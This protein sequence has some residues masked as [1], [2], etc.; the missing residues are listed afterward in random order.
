[1]NVTGEAVY[2]NGVL[3]PDQPLPLN[4][5]QRVRISVQPLPDDPGAMRREL[6]RRLA[7]R[8]QQLLSLVGDVALSP[9][10]QLLKRELAQGHELLG[11]SAG[12]EGF[13]SP[14]VLVESA[15]VSTTWKQLTRQ[16]LEAIRDVFLLG[17]TAPIRFEDQEQ[18]RHLLRTAGLATLPQIDLEA[19]PE[20]ELRDDELTRQLSAPG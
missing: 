8:T 3:R 17:E 18:A 10:L 11:G 6:A 12:E 2:E 1:M 15:L 16:H 14:I 4:D 20:D 9:N 19:L 5:R 7:H 13:L